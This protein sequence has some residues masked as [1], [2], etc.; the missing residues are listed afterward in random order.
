MILFA[1]VCSFGVLTVS[2]LT[3]WFVYDDW[4]HETGP[5]RLIGTGMAALLTFLVVIRWQ[6]GVR[7]KHREMMVHFEQIARMNDRIRNALQAIEC[8]TYAAQ[9]PAAQPVREAVETIDGVLSEVLADAAQMPRPVAAEI[10]NA[11][12]ESQAKHAS[13]S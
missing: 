8:V 6:L 12:A 1:V 9:S 10:G 13:R 11:P 4:L 5:L 3:Q 2:L 7:E